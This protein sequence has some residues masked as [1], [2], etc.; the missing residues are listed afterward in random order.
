M[1]K[2]QGRYDKQLEI[3]PDSNA[4]GNLMVCIEPRSIL[5]GKIG[6]GISVSRSELIKKLWPE[7]FSLVHYVAHSTVSFLN[8]KEM[9]KKALAIL[10]EN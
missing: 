2:I 4:I 7:G 1:I 6:M 10:E 9:A 5:S 8:D 3:E